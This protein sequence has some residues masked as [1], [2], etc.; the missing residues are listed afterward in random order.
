MQRVPMPCYRGEDHMPKRA[1]APK[2]FYTA[3]DVMRILDIGNSTLYHYVE[4]GKI[5]KV[6]PPERK[7][8]YYVKADIDK[9]IQ[10]REAFILQ[11]A[12]D[13]TSFNVAQ[14]EDIEGVTNLGIELFGKYGIEDYE[15]RLS[16]HRAN[17]DIFYVLKQED[18]VVGYVGLFPL[19][20]EAIESIMAG[21]EESRFRTN[22]LAPTNILPFVVGDN[23]ELFLIIGAKQDV[24]KSK[25]YGA[26]LISGTI[27]VLEHF[28]RKGILI[29][30]LYATSRTRDGIR[31]CK[32]LG[33][34]QTTPTEEEDDL[35]RFKLNL[36]TATNPLFKKYQRIVDR[37]ANKKE[38]D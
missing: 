16:Q 6:V 35:L 38:N 9:L 28:A 23:I 20:H 5:K 21:M 11:Y 8:G 17:P 33:F 18:I 22:I 19:K 2:G 3:S 36:K 15:M 1:K 27:E 10:A 14:E 24:K 30:T 12:D 29:E 31:L 7:E 4:I 32:G 13:T 25:I 26:R 34:E 37:I